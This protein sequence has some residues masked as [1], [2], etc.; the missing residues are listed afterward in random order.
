MLSGQKKHQM[1]TAKHNMGRK[2]SAALGMKLRTSLKGKLK[3]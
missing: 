1:G 3:K 2:V